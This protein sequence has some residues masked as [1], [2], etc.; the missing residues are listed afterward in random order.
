[1]NITDIKI[2]RLLREGRLRAVVSVTVDNELAIHDIKV[3]EAQ[4]KLFIVMPSRK[5]GDGTYRD[6]AHPINAPFRHTL[7]HAV[8][9]AY[10][11][12]ADEGGTAAG[13]TQS[14]FSSSFRM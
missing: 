11:H 6:I 4:E 1:M 3:I 8:L 10:R 5:N 14:P 2:R 7:E 9:D 13:D 12:H